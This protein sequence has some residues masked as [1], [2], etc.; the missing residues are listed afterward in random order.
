MIRPS[1]L[2]PR[3]SVSGQISAADVAR[4]KERG[5]CSIICNRPD[6]EASRQP[7]FAEIEDAAQ[8]AGLETLYLPVTPDTL[9]DQTVSKFAEAVRTLPAPILAYCRSGA[10]SRTLW[11]RSQGR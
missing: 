2:S 3:L 10:R 7:S 5:F 11:R 4:L 9:S 1:S 8:R 6:G